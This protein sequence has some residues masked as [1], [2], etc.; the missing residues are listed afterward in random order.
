MR[1][2][3][4]ETAEADCREERKTRVVESKLSTGETTTAA[5][6]ER[7]VG[8]TDGAF[9]VC[10]LVFKDTEQQERVGAAL[11]ERLGANERRSLSTVR[12]ASTQALVTA[13]QGDGKP[14]V[15]TD[16]ERWPGGI[17]DAGLTLNGARDRLADECPRPILI[18]TSETNLTAM[19]KAGADLHSW[20]SGTFDFAS[21]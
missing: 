1:R 11:A 13:L 9:R 14:I 2:H 12:E 3:D 6:L 4:A 20:S 8:R 16:L 10:Y 5:R 18:C 21:A 19:L 7:A 17:E 15:V